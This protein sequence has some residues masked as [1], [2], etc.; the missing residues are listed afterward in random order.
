MRVYT[1]HC[2][3]GSLEP[4]AGAILVK[5]G[6]SWP[7]FLIAPFWL[8]YQRL[9]LALFAVVVF[10]LALDL[11]LDLAGADPLTG[12]IA[13]AGF[14]LF[15]GLEANDWRR[16]KLNRRGYRMAGIIA[17]DDHDGAMHRYFDRNP[18]EPPKFHRITGSVLGGL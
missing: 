1:V 18:H 12:F 6:F 13:S 17:A 5:E 8:L 4:D 7:A 14:A 16:A 15:I 9:W 3:P 11:G 2:W 10:G